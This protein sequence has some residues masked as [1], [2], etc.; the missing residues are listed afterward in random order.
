MM[1]EEMKKERDR[2]QKEEKE[3]RKGGRVGNSHI[4]TEAIFKYRL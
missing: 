2:V 4:Y 3:K 1:K